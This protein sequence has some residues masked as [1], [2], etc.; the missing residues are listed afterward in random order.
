MGEKDELRGIINSAFDRGEQSALRTEEVNGEFKVK[1]FGAWCP[2]VFAGIGNAIHPT[3]A[4]RSIT[5]NMRRKKPTD[6]VS[7]LRR[8]DCAET[9]DTIKRMLRRWAQDNTDRLKG[10]DPAL[11]EALHD[12]AGD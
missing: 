4:D 2:K 10:S 12:R 9:F 7:R 8:R 6:K 5:I 3:T 1:R 11:P